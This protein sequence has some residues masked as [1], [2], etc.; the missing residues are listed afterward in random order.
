MEDNKFAI[1]PSESNMIVVLRVIGTLWIMLV[2]LTTVLPVQGIM[3]D[4][5]SFGADGVK[6]F[7]ILTGFLVSYSW[8]NR[9]STRDYW[10]KRIC[11]I[12]PVYYI[13]L[14]FWIVVRF[15]WFIADP[16]SIPRSLLMLEYI[17]PPT[18]GSYEYCHLWLV[19]VLSI[20][21]MFYLLIPVI[22]RKVKTTNGMMTMLL[23]YLLLMP[24]LKRGLIYLYG[25]ISNQDVAAEMIGY[26]LPT[27]GYMMFGMVIFYARNEKKTNRSDSIRNLVGMFRYEIFI[28]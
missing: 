8:V 17:A 13:M 26:L 14:A 23:V 12:F 11:R 25:L 6:I 10:K 7:Y 16:W 24:V 19:G 22:G 15:E 9:K 2:H 28:F 1:S 3:K 27:F 5:M 18:G 20:F 4:I 21:M